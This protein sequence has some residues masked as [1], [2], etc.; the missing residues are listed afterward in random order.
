MKQNITKSIVLSVTTI[1]TLGMTGCSSNSNKIAGDNE[2]S[3]YSKGYYVDS[4]VRGVS[5]ECGNKTG[6]TDDKGMFYFGSGV[7]CTFKASGIILRIVPSGDL[8]AGTTIVEDDIKVARFLQSMDM[9][10]IAG[11]GINLSDELLKALN[12]AGKTSVPVTD[13]EIEDFR[14]IIKNVVPDYRGKVVS[15][16][17]AKAH[18]D[19]TKKLLG[20]TI[21]YSGLNLGLDGYLGLLGRSINIGTTFGWTTKH[22]TDGLLSNLSSLDSKILQAELELVDVDIDASNQSKIDALLSG[23]SKLRSLIEQIKQKN[24]QLDTAIRVGSNVSDVNTII[25][26]IKFLVKGD[27]YD[28][29]EGLANYGRIPL[30]TLS[31]NPNNADQMEINRYLNQAGIYA[32][33]FVNGLTSIYVR[34]IAVSKAY[35]Q[36]LQAK[37]KDAYDT[38]NDTNPN[39]CSVANYT[40]SIVLDPQVIGQCQMAFFYTCAI[41]QYAS[42]YPDKV[43]DMQGNVKT[44]CSI[45]DGYKDFTIDGTSP[46]DS[47]DYCDDVDNYNTSTLSTTVVN[48]CNHPVQGGRYNFAVRDKFIGSFRHHDDAQNVRLDADG[49]GHV[50]FL[51]DGSSIDK[52]IASWGEVSF[53]NTS[54]IVY[55]TS[56]KINDPQNCQIV[57]YDEYTG[58]I[59]LYNISSGYFT[60][61]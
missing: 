44:A 55:I 26:E 51:S 24:I 14:T 35:T 58:D 28:Y 11:N 50:T 4:A 38:K 6:L 57:Q 60:Q 36:S 9:D 1:F 42:S 10:G 7:S 41:T 5:Y 13:S 32:L 34:M 54:F 48:Q 21:D 33:S 30:P 40:N 29:F 12:D 56:D 3:N 15:M 43:I 25:N 49:T 22:E 8:K 27:V 37:I 2:S 53:G 18:V 16:I 46:K 20:N 59:R 31:T 52:E 39:S 45:L 19:T 17:D 61:E 23:K 47:C